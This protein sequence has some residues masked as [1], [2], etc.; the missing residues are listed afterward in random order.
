MTR[1]VWLG[2]A[3]YAI[4]G[5]FPIYWK[6]FDA[7][8]AVQ[9]IAHRIAWSF[10]VLVPA[11][12]ISVWRESRAAGS[13]GIYASSDTV[14]VYAT[15]ALLIALNWFI[16]VWAVNHGLIV[17]TSL[18]YFITPLINVLLGVVVLRESLRRW[19]WVAVAIAAAGVAYLTVVYGAVPWI[20]IAL[21]VS[22][23][24]YG[25]VKKKAPMAPLAGLTLET[26]ILFIPAVAFLGL[27]EWHGTGAFGHAGMVPTALMAGA[28]VVT[29][30][31]LLLFATAVRQIPLSVIGILQFIAPTIQF[32]LG[33]FVYREPFSRS[34]LA[35]FSL[36]WLALAVFAIDGAVEQGRRSGQARLAG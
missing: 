28:G 26:G 4:W 1:G 25:L 24:T 21:A 29:T 13:F 12:A 2:A 35:G 3:A 7:V 10:I 16:Y 6:L 22:F 11:L 19:Q 8:P 31:P 15:A 14:V 32:L 20:A 36:V 9:I 33:V 34:Q 27:V 18:G 17:E 23:G 5:L 30:V